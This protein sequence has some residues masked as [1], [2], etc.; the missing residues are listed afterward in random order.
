MDQSYIAENNAERTRL[1][2]LVARLTD[3]DP[4]QATS[5]DWTVGVGLLHLAFWDRPLGEVRGVG[6]HGDS[7]HPAPAGH[8]GR[9]QPGHAAL[10]ADRRP[11]PDQI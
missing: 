7:R 6:A 5:E 2:A 1:Q 10:V 11:G 8:G 3:A 4:A 9:D